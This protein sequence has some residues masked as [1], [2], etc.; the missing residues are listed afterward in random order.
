LL[1]SERPEG[2]ARQMDPITPIRQSAGCDIGQ[3]QGHIRVAVGV[4]L[5]SQVQECYRAFVNECLQRTC[6]R[7]LVL[8][9]AR[10]DEFQHLALRDV[11]RSMALVGLPAGFRLAL[12]PMTPN[13]IAIYDA[14]VV[15][16]ARHGIEVRRFPSEEAAVRWLAN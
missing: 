10:I 16:A 9:T 8:G 14:V 4:G 6:V 5:A 12:V 11:L 2:F 1:G 13:L 7:A 3:A 15:E